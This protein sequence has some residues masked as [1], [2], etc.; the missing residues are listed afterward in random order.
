[1]RAAAED[2]DWRKRRAQATPAKPPPMM[3]IVFWDMFR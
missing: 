2:N 1:M 3:A